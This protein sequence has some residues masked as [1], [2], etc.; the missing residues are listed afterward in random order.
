MPRRARNASGARA[1]ARKPEREEPDRDR[2]DQPDRRRLGLGQVRSRV[3]A[4]SEDIHLVLAVGAFDDIVA[5][6]TQAERA[7]LHRRQSYIFVLSVYN[8]SVTASP[9]SPVPENLP[10]APGVYLFRN[11]KSRII[12][13]GKARSLKKRV[14]SYFHKTIDDTKTR[15][16][17]SEQTSVETIVTRTELEALLL[18]NSLIK[19]HHPRYNVCL[20]DDKT[21]PYVKITTGENGRGRS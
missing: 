13:V 1:R 2:R 16:L 12:Y 17:L 15:A 18:E 20:R 6:R 4:R 5:D 9:S 19:K 3:E 8:L 21:Y 11:A 14:S 10:E 7:F